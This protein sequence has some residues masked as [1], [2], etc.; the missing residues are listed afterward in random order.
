M[1]AETIEHMAR[2]EIARAIAAGGPIHREVRSGGG[3]NTPDEE[4]RPACGAGQT[5]A[6]VSMPYAWDLVSTGQR[7]PACVAALAKRGG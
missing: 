3:I 1:I 4:W 2:D 6:A 7:C 5:N